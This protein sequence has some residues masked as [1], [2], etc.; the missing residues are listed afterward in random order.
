MKFYLKKKTFLNLAEILDAYRVVPRGIVIAYS[1]MLW[2]ITS[3]FM[4]LEDPT[5]PQS[6]FV[7]VVYG[8]SAGMFAFYAN[9]GRKWNNEVGPHY[10]PY[11]RG[12]PVEDV[13]DQRRRR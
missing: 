11:D 6:M 9:S 12:V 2:N 5:N 1:Y 13:L 4:A 10:D 3:W 7:S 8:A